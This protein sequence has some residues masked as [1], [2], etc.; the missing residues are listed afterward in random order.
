[1]LALGA[2]GFIPKFTSLD[3]LRQVIEL[4]LEE[5]EDVQRL[6][7]AAV[8]RIE[9]NRRKRHSLANRS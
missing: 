7:R 5:T 8:D 2:T 4:T 6:V 3:E 1:V 9:A